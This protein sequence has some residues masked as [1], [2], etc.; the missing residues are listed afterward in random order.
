MERITSEDRSEWLS[1]RIPSTVD[2]G[3]PPTSNPGWYRGDGGQWRLDPVRRASWLREGQHA[4]IG[5]LTGALP[6]AAYWW[7]DLPL[8]A[9]ALVAQL[10][11]VTL[12]LAYEVTEGWRIRDWAYRDIG[13][14]MAGM[15]VVHL[16]RPR[17]H[18]RLSRHFVTA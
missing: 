1:R 4:L 5:G 11:A 10:L 9:A 16:L 17:R 18:P 3:G 15:L 2:P 7:G 13:G 8:V 12:F 14:F 6:Y